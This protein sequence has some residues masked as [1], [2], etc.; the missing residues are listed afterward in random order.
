MT[1]SKSKYALALIFLLFV[2]HPDS[3][4]RHQNSQ[5]TKKTT[6][7]K[8][9]LFF[10]N[11]LTAGYGLDMSLAF[12]NLIQQKIDSLGWHFVAVNAGLSGETSA[13]GYRRIDW[14]L[15]QPV[16]ALV[17]ELGGNDALRGIDLTVTK[18]NLQGIINKTRDKYPDVKI[19]IAGM[20]VPPNFGQ[21]YARQFRDL[22]PALAETNQAYLIP[23]LLA[24][25]GGSP[26]LNQPDGIHP[27]AKGHRI[28]AENVWQVLRPVLAKMNPIEKSTTE[29]TESH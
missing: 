4:A 21:T 5:N 3:F 17:L 19:V 13:G 7:F 29:S 27:T 14:L 22:F 28:I 15:R 11:S 16:A 26:Q 25:V 1:I 12:P 23:F 8:R 20:L 6:T 2:S 24:G 10:G 9:I 18:R